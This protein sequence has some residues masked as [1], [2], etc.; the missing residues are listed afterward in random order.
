M[1]NACV[2]VWF[3]IIS[4]S[5][6]RSE[7]CLPFKLTHNIKVSIS[8]SRKVVILSWLLEF[9][10]L[11]PF[12]FPFLK[13]PPKGKYIP[14][15]TCHPCRDIFYCPLTTPGSFYH[16]DTPLLS[17]KQPTKNPKPHCHVSYP[18]SA[19]R[20]SSFA[21]CLLQFTFQKVKIERKMTRKN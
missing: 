21:T 8:I 7:R 13:T 5:L 2:K 15:D 9:K 11:P 20:I 17:L 14:S 3:S 10:R 16:Q 4:Y 18:Q 6:Q 1:K 19:T 12:L